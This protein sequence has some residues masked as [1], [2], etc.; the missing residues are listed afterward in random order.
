MLLNI[1]KTFGV[2]LAI[3]L[4]TILHISIAY[5]LPHPF[6][7]L[8]VIF[9]MILTFLLVFN[10]GFVVWLTFFTHFIIELYIVSTPFGVILFA[11]TMSIL[12]AFWL[13]KNIL[14]NHAWYVGVVLSI[15]T[16]AFYRTLYIL[17]LLILI[18]VSKEL[19]IDWV[20]L[21]I[22]FLWEILFTSLV[23]GLV[24]TFLLLAWPSINKKS[25]GVGSFR[26]ILPKK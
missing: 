7:F 3:F 1:I 15:I 5:I 18:L 8:N 20:S 16:L 9:F 10:R 26:L 4:S 24:Y 12:F 25:S 17:S 13:Y 19:V 2:A 14:T 11:S 6:S 22:S 21:L 23:V